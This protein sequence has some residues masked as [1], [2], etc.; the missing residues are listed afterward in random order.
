MPERVAPRPPAPGGRRVAFPH[1]PGNPRC[2]GQ[3]V[4]TRH[5]T[6]ELV[7]PRPLRRGLR[8]AAVAELDERRRLHPG[9][10]P[11]PV[12]GPGP[13]P[14]SP[15]PRSSARRRTPSSSARCS[16]AG[17]GEPLAFS[18]R[19]VKI[20]EARRGEFDIVHDNQCLGSGILELHRRGWPLLETLH[21]PDHRRPFDRPRPRRVPRGSGSTT[22]RWFGFLAHAGPRRASSCLRCSRCR[23]NSRV[24]INKAMHVPLE[25][26]TVVPVRGRPHRVPAGPGG[27]GEAG[28]ADGRR[29]R[30]TSP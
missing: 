13:V 19:I 11:R 5:L 15:L 25:R 9:A 23:P 10:R 6:R 18:R 17:F 1:L 22:R 20:L 26:L 7:E 27:R 21:H 2:G 29:R 3:G 14:Q 16:A 28:A 4:Y 30:P 8:G 24:D 12:S